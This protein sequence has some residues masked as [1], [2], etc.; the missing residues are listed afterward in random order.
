MKQK[1]ILLTLGALVIISFQNCAK[2]GFENQDLLSSVD[3]SSTSLQTC[4]AGILSCETDS[5]YGQQTCTQVSAQN[6]SLGPCLISSCKTGFS[7]ISGTCVS[8]ACAPSSQVSCDLTNGTGSRICDQNGQ[9]GPCSNPVCNPGFYL[10]QGVCA[11]EFVSVKVN[12]ASEIMV[13][14][15]QIYQIN[16]TTSPGAALNDVG[17]S[18]TAVAGSCPANQ[19][20]APLNKA[21]KPWTLDGTTNGVKLKIGTNPWNFSGNLMQDMTGC[22][23]KGCVVTTNGASS[24]LLIDTVCPTGKYLIG[25]DCGVCPNGQQYNSSTHVCLPPVTPTPTT[26]P[27]STTTTTTMKPT[28]TTVK[29]TTTTTMKV[30]CNFNGQIMQPGE[31]LIA[32]TIGTAPQGDFCYNHRQLRYCGL[33]GVLTGDAKYSTCVDLP[34][35]TTTTT[36]KPTTTTTT[37]KSTTTTT[38]KPKSTT[39]TTLKACASG[40]SHVQTWNGTTICGYTC[41]TYLAT[42]DITYYKCPNSVYIYVSKCTSGPAQGSSWSS[43]IMTYVPTKGASFTCSEGN[44]H[45]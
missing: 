19:S 5:G 34:A 4:P 31:S 10:N 8:A 20:W 38:M 6:A 13:A 14:P 37:V 28:T 12:N 40:L 25:N 42:G 1:L 35:P 17:S 45:P 27:P 30:T 29:P 22:Q 21:L 16:V 32:F 33:D 3:Q 39:T 41:P 9:Y 11:P 44:V 26:L 15:L 24:C 2:N 18:L 43:I 36:M 7:Y 23:W